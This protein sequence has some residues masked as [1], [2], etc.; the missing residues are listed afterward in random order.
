M[1]LAYQPEEVI[2]VR[3][4]VVLLRWTTRQ[5]VEA[6]IFRWKTAVG[7][8]KTVCLTG[9]HIPSLL[10]VHRMMAVLARWLLICS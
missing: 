6:V 5:M 8:W 4:R 9:E 10:S 2:S 1:G 7:G 3:I